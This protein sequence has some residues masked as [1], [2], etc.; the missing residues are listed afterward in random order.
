MDY[1]AIK[2]KATGFYYRGRGVNRWGK[3][4]NQASI[5]RILGQAKCS[6]EEI[7]RRGEKE[8]VIIKL[9]IKES[10]LNE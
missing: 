8:S 3:Y 9:D 10:E 6:L 7:H 1:Y 4:L 2:D 5:F